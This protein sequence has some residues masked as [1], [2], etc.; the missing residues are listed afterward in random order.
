MV[1]HGAP[2]PETPEKPARARLLVNTLRKWRIRPLKSAED[3]EAEDNTTNNSN[4][5]SPTPATGRNHYFR[6]GKSSNKRSP[7]NSPF[8]SAQENNNGDTP[9]S[10]LAG[11]V[12]QVVDEKGST[13]PSSDKLLAGRRTPNVI[14]PTSSPSV[15][16]NEL[17]AGPYLKPQTGRYK[18]LPTLVLDLDETLVHSSFVE[19]ANYHFVI[20]VNIEGVI[21]AIYVAK[22]PG[23]DDFL[24]KVSQWYEVVIFTASLEKYAAPLMDK[25]DPGRL[26]V[27]RLFR[28]RC[29][30]WNGQYVKDLTRMGREIQKLVIV[31][32]S[33][34]S[35]AFQ[36]QNAV[37]IG[38]WFDDQNDRELLDLIPL[39]AELAK[40][41]SIPTAIVATLQSKG[42]LLTPLSTS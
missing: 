8:A 30:V 34:N 31:D 23:V 28:E 17:N 19:V 2:V 9:S 14:Q 4:N 26:C 39:L 7:F 37:P 5:R 22:R 20:P 6:P 33:P 18:G 40:V 38:S 13:T 41:P 42:A 1:A 35:Y 32:N 29:I 24:A 16:V 27:H 25:L 11:L 21:H 12:T 36:P 10:A 3:D 15:I